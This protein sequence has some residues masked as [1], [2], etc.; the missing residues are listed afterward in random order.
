MAGRCRRASLPLPPRGRGR[1]RMGRS[2]PYGR[3]RYPAVA[4]WRCTA[5]AA[6]R[7]SRVSRGQGCRSGFPGWYKAWREAYDRGR[8]RWPR[9]R[10]IR[11]AGAPIRPRAIE[12]WARARSSSVRSAKAP[13]RPRMGN[14]ARSAAARGRSI[15]RLGSIGRSLQ[16][17][18]AANG[19]GEKARRVRRRAKDQPRPRSS[20]RIG[21]ST[22]S[23]CVPSGRTANL[24]RSG[25]AATS[26][27]GS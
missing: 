27:R 17:R 19:R 21:H 18:E 15:Q 13:A 1:A 8:V 26:F 20:L 16:R 4:G 10:R 14:P 7:S 25:E 22:V 6:A 3:R 9:R 12:G 11:R 24:A 2:S 5:G 23:G